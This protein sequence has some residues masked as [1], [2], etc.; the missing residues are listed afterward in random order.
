MG[1][2]YPL[3]RSVPQDARRVSF[4]SEPFAEFRYRCSLRLQ[5]PAYLQAPD[6]IRDW[7]RPFYERR[8]PASLTVNAIDLRG[9]EAEFV[10]DD[11]D[12]TYDDFFAVCQSLAESDAEAV[13]R[14]AIS[15]I[16]N[17]SNWRKIEIVGQSML[18]STV[19]RI[20]VSEFRERFPLSRIELPQDGERKVDV[21]LYDGLQL[22]NQ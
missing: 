16:N 13:V 22:V 9:V 17:N 6:D 4:L 18:G 2:A 1:L 14:Y 8:L 3:E 19:E 7:L 11:A 12:G 5:E 20:S 21:I 10:F 15:W